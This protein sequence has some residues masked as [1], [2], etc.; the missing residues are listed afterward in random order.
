MLKIYKKD[1]NI[2]AKRIENSF[3]ENENLSKPKSLEEVLNE[4]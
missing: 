3:R 1:K 4:Y 2:S